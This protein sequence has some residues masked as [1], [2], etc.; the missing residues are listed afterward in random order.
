M[1]VCMLYD[2]MLCVCFTFSYWTTFNF[3]NKA[4]HSRT[5]LNEVHQ[6]VRSTMIDQ[7][8]NTE[9][10][11]GRKPRDKS[12]FPAPTPARRQGGTCGTTSC[13]V[14]AE[15]HLPTALIPLSGY[16]ASALPRGA[17]KWKKK[18]AVRTCALRTIVATGVA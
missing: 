13:P 18:T 17:A 6:S 10:K 3:T 15:Y 2:E 7:R 12:S 14:P 16:C 5:K 1:R 8:R 4:Q 9:S 11:H